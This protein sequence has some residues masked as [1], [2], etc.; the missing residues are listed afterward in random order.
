MTSKVRGLTETELA[1]IS[2][3]FADFGGSA[4]AIPISG[5]GRSPT[6]P[7]WGADGMGF[8]N[9][10]ILPAGPTLPLP[11]PKPPEPGKP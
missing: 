4:S 1:K 5:G 9:W 2:G 6:L 11:I 7:I 8:G 3:G 10:W